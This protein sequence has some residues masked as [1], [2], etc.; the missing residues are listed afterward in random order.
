MENSLS[1]LKSLGGGGEERPPPLRK[2][3]GEWLRKSKS[4]EKLFAASHWSV[5]SF[6]CDFQWLVVRVKVW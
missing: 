4:R 1:A 2:M 3:N 5:E 6:S